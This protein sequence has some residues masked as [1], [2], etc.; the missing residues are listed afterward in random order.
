M[1]EQM[2]QLAQVTLNFRDIDGL[3][4]QLE[5]LKQQNNFGLYTEIELRKD[6]DW[7]WRQEQA[8]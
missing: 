3:I 5:N 1:S 4:K 8:K 2:T 7:V 6:W